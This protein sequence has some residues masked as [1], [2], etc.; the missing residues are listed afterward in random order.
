MLLG[1]DAPRAERH[2][3]DG[4][5]QRHRKIKRSGGRIRRQ[6]GAIEGSDHH[7]Y[8]RRDGFELEGHIG[9][10]PDQRDER[11]D[12][13]DSLRFSI[14][15]GYEIGDRGDVLRTG[16]IGDAGDEWRPEADD[17]NGPN[18][19]GQKIKA[20]RGGESRPSRSRSRT[21]NRRRD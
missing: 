1:V 5:Q 21:C 20:M 4:E 2:R 3:E 11:G 14:P 6:A 8:G 15:G 17:K 13:G 9:G 19:D 18:V 10:R 12:C 16:E 7:Q